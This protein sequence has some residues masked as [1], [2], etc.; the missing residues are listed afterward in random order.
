MAAKIGFIAAAWTTLIAY[1]TMMTISYV[2]GQKHYKV[3]Y[4]LNKIAL[5]ILVAALLSGLS[6]LKLNG[7]YYLNT[8]TLLSF[9]VLIMVL[10]RTEIK[11]L[12]RKNEN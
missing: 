6:Y 10:E 7:N 9:I 4:N 2:M 3:P 12:L 1:A 5:Y 8:I 11:E